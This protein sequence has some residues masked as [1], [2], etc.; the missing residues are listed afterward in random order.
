MSIQSAILFDFN[1]TLYDPE[2]KELFPEVRELLSYYSK[3]H[4]LYLV[5]KKEQ[6][7]FDLIDSLEIKHFFNSVHFVERKSPILFKEV[8]KDVQG[9]VYVVGDVVHSEIKAGNMCGMKTIWFQ[10]GAFADQRPKDDME[11]PWHRIQTLSELYT[12]IK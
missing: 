5:S 2:R 6:S 1:R 11:R 3:T 10:N 8:T 7:R 12:L 9:E 4:Q